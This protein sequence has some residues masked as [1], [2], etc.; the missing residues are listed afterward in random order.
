M[1]LNKL[2]LSLIITLPVANIACDPA[3]EIS[4]NTDLDVCSDT[5]EKHVEFINVAAITYTL[6]PAPKVGCGVTYA[7]LGAAAV[8]FS[9]GQLSIKGDGQAASTSRGRGGSC[10][11]G[12]T[13]CI[14]GAGDDRAGDAGPLTTM[15]GRGPSSGC[16]SRC[17][18]WWTHR[19]HLLARDNRQHVP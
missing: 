11:T 3:Q 14:S 18:S 17:I 7:I 4:M 2:A 12:S 19:L 15:V 6:P 9:G 13:G 10:G 5:A 1:M 8:T 16:S